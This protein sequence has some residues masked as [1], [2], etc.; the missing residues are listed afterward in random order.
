MSELSGMPGSEGYEI[1]SDASQGGTSRE[2]VL[3][4][5]NRAPPG[6][7]D[8]GGRPQSPGNHDIIKGSVHTTHRTKSIYTRVTPQEKQH[9]LVRA[10]TCGLSVSEYLRQRA[11][12][13]FPKALPP[14]ELHMLKSELLRLRKAERSA[15]EDHAIQSVL[16]EI[17][18]TFILPGR[19]S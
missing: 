16:D 13:Y 19:D 11:L 4:V 18:D 7:S 10:R 14:E 12:G 5:P 8:F 15:D 2:L 9:I 3:Q 17:R 1:A 6:D